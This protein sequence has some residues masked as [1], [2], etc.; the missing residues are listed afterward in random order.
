MRRVAT[1]TSLRQTDHRIAAANAA[2][3]Q[4]YKDVSDQRK[5]EILGEAK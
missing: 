1:M 4:N 5:A 2:I 3:Q